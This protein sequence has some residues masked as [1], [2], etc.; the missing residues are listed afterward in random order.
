[1]TFFRFTLKWIT[2]HRTLSLLGVFIVLGIMGFSYFVKNRSAGTF[3]EPLEKGTIIDAVYGIGTVTANK[4][5]RI[6]PGLVTNVTQVWVKA[7]DTV[8]K[9][10]K[11]IQNDANV[12]RAPF[13][14]TVTSLSFKAGENTFIATPILTLVDM[15]D[16]YLVVSM[17]QQGALQVKP[18]Q[19]VKLSFDTLREQSYDGEVEALYA[20]DTSYL[21]RIKLR[22]IPSQILPGMTADTA[23]EISRH[24]NILIGPV[25]ALENG[26]EVWRKRGHEIPTKIQIKIGVI[27]KDKFE[28]VSGELRE[29]DLLLIRKDLRR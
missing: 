19:K 13:D 5:W 17:E 9:G 24:D 8:K 7:G 25:A 14:G 4:V 3:T 22:S 1:M 18:G 10:A 29:G 27:D 21:A 26:Q 12:W 11:L 15:N 23:I 2:A 6:T 20:S 16:R 28:I